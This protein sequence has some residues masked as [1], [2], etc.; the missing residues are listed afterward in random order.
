MKA[1]FKLI[2]LFIIFFWGI[3]FLI[4]A[5]KSTQSYSYEEMGFCEDY[6]EIDS[7]T[8]DRTHS[9]S[10]QLVDYSATY[11]TNYNSY[12]SLYRESQKKRNDII[13]KS[14][15]YSGYWGEV[16]KNL[17]TTNDDW[18]GFI[19]D[20]LLQVAFSD[21]LDAHGLAELTVSF[22]QDIPYHFISSGDCDKESA[23]KHP[24]VAQAKFG[25]LSPYEFLH[26]LSGD[27][28]TRAVLLYSLLQQ[29][30]FDP[31]IVVSYEYRHAMLALNLPAS[32]DHLTL[33][34]K[35]YYFWETT[36]K[37]WP[38]GMIPPDMQNLDYWNIALV[39]EL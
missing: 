2:G 1:V 35:N 34:G 10:W 29:M 7:I 30:N 20:S 14:S 6:T 28:D 12:E 27:C 16:Y 24:C 3:L 32:G 17:V 13:P 11:C 19:A 31:M 26:S 9:R 8:F 38:L 39:N 15:D 25:I 4:D 33:G 18:V 21:S 22:V 37:G 36:A 23:G 5:L